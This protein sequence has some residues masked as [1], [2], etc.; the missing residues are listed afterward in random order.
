MRTPVGSR[1]R[2]GLRGEPGH[3]AK[4]AAVAMRAASDVDAGDALPEGGERF[5]GGALLGRGGGRI[6]GGTGTSQKR[7]LV[8]VG[9]EPVVADAVEA[10]RQH[11]QREAA[12]ELLGVERQGLA[13]RAVGVVL[14]AKAHRAR[15]AGYQPLVG[16]RAAV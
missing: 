3:D 5:R 1:R 12:Q 4:R 8:A 13:A 15:L 14:V 6:E 9:K 16:D 10:A 11:V 7:A 2:M